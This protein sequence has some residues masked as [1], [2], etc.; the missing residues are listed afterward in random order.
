MSGKAPR[1]TTNEATDRLARM[2][3]NLL[4]SRQSFLG[5]GQLD[6]PKRNIE[7]ECGYPEGEPT[8]EL[9][10]HVYERIGVGTRIVQVYPEESWSIHPDVYEIESPRFTPFEKA[11]DQFIFD[12]DPWHYLH[13]LDEAAG[14]GRC[15]ALLMV[16]DDGQALS[17]SIEGVNA[18]GEWDG[19]T[20]AKLRNFLYMRPFS[21]DQFTVTKVDTNWNSP[22]C[23]Q[24]IEYS[25]RVDSATDTTDTNILLDADASKTTD[26][27]VH[28]TRVLHVADNCKS[29]DIF[30]TPRLKPVL[31][32]VLGIRKISYSA[33]E[34]FYKGAFPG[35]SFEAL[36]EVATT[37]ELDTDSLKAEIEAYSLGLQRYMRLVGMTAKSLAPQVADPSAQLL[38]ILQLICS[39]IKVPLRVFMG[40]EA[41]YLASQMDQITWNRRLKG[42][43]DRFVW[44][45][46]IKPFVRRLQWMGV[47]PKTEMFA[48]YWPDLNVMTD[49]DKA[50]VSLQKAQALLQYVTSG[51]MV[52][53]PPKIFL[54]QVMNF[55]DREADAIIKAGGGE[56]KMIAA[57]NKKL[58]QPVEIAR[59]KADT[60]PDRRT[61]ALGQRNGLGSGSKA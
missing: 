30:G 6:Q 24:P 58:S 59:M 53:M 45:R 8:L 44:P 5:G 57:M 34:M 41:G 7:R 13:R 28:W 52:V 22:R 2:T 32:D 27:R 46:I 11:L 56:D 55:S 33:P 49:T 60:K 1:M 12:H 31:N 50:K 19:K 23:G 4:L 26:F 25:F 10:R 29:S 40:T 37:A 36:P 54:T 51:S 9:Y 21:E 17:R 20:P 16:H 47:L 42:R 61:G 43:Q 18:R 14:I 48:C 38:A 15:G 39:A 3:V 35:I